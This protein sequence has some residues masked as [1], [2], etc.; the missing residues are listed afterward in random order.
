MNVVG[1]KIWG[2]SDPEELIGTRT[3]EVLRGLASRGDAEKLQDFYQ[4]AVNAGKGGA[5]G[6]GA[7]NSRSPVNTARNRV[8][9]LQEIIEAWS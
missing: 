6:R 9:L 4:G 7:Q 8:Q 5:A 1:N 3:P 2:N